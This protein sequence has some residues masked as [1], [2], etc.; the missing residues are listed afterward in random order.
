MEYG[1]SEQVF[2]IGLMIWIDEPVSALT[3]FAVEAEKSGFRELWFPDHYFL[4]DVYITMASIA[5]RTKTIRLG[6]AVAAVQLRHPA[7][8]ASSALICRESFYL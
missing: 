2:E 4:R 7:L 5:Q 3:E 6:T 8:I 1:M